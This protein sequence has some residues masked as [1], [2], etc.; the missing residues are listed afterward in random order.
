[1]HLVW[2]CSGQEGEDVHKAGVEHEGVVGA[3]H[4]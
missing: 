4:I 2:G 3:Q 1:M